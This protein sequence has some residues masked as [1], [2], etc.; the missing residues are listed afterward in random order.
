M[1]RWLKAAVIL[2]GLFGGI[3]EAQK[4]PKSL[5]PEPKL[6][7]VQIDRYQE[8]IW[9]PEIT[10]FKSSGPIRIIL[11]DS[12]THQKTTIVAD[13]AEGSVNGDIIVKG[14]VKIERAE[15]DLTGFGLTY[16]AATQT[17][18]VLRATIDA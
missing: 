18:S 9:K 1:R 2:T 7:E 5:P 16:H 17:G 14:A 12:V 6:G 8:L 15:G 4:K 10:Y 13:D 11:E 3:A